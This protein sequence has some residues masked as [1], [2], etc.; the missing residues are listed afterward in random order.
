[1][2]LV[3]FNG[4]LHF[5]TLYVEFNFGQIQGVTLLRCSHLEAFCEKKI[6]PE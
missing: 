5:C 1:M 4:K 2:T 3:N 6:Y